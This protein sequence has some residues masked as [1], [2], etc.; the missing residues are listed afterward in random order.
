MF[1][2]GINE[3]E[4]KFKTF[5][6]L[7]VLLFNVWRG[8]AA[9]TYRDSDL[10]RIV[11]EYRNYI[12]QVRTLAEEAKRLNDQL[13]EKESQ[14][15]QLHRSLMEISK[16]PQIHD[17]SM[18]KAEGKDA[19]YYDNGEVRYYETCAEAHYVAKGVRAYSEKE[20][21]AR[22]VGP[23]DKIRVQLLKKL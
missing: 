11:N 14:I 18:W 22:F 12:S 3:F 5:D 8:N 6:R 1:L 16:N 20:I 7:N 10:A 17:C 19:V 15:T 4:L 2:R 21:A 9:D 23:C 13:A